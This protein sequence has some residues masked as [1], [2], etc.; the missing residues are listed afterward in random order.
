MHTHAIH[1]I[2]IYIYI[3]TVRQFVELSE[4]P[5]RE[6]GEGP[7]TWSFIGTYIYIY[8]YMY[9]YMSIHVCYISMGIIAILY[10]P[11]VT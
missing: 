11:V 4:R 2:Y 5:P 7:R 8:I 1:P 6:G 3:Y 9:I 10:Y